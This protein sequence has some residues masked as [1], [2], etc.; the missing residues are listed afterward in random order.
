[1]FQMVV[2]PYAGKIDQG[3][4]C[5]KDQSLCDIHYVTK[6]FGYPKMCI[7]MNMIV[8]FSFYKIYHVSYFTIALTPICV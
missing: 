2:Y 5:T 1:M 3:F 4:R 6:I 8:C 7:L